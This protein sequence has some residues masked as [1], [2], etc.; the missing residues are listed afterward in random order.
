ML[1]FSRMADR[2][3]LKHLALRAHSMGV[4][5]FPSLPEVGSSLVPLRIYLSPHRALTIRGPAK[6][7][8]KK[9]R[10]LDI[11]WNCWTLLDWSKFIKVSSKSRLTTQRLDRIVLRIKLPEYGQPSLQAGASYNCAITRV[12]KTSHGL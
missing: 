3:S 4:W 9:D 8:K 12:V 11:A 7:K 1:H 2:L 5:M 10:D 6:K